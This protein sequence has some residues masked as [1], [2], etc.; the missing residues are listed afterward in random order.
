MII[1]Q[2]VFRVD[3]AER[4]AYLAQSVEAMQRSR[5]ERGCLE[6]VFAADPVEADR[7]VLSERWASQEE[8]DEHIAGMGRR[9]QEPADRG[10]APPPVKVLSREVAMYEVSAAKPLG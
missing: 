7:V 8:L 2:G 4:D 10:D 5:A 9:R 6:Y 1:V 3:P